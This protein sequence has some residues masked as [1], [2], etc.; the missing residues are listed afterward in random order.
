MYYEYESM[1]HFKSTKYFETKSKELL[2]IISENENLTPKVI[3]YKSNF[4]KEEHFALQ[5]LKRNQDIRF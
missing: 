4:S 5:Y 2:F 3:C 1:L